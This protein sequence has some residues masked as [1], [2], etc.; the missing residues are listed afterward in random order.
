MHSVYIHIPFCENIC[1]YCAFTKFYYNEY[2]VTEYLDSLRYEIE[3]NYKGELI[4]TIYIGGG[5]PS[6]LSISELKILF[7]IINIFK[8]DKDVEF[9]I[10]VNPES[11]TKEKL[12][13]FKYNRVNRISMGVESTNNKSLKYLG[14]NYDFNTVR[15]KIKLIKSLGFNNINVDLMY[16]LPSET[17]EDLEMD[18]DNILDLDITHIS[19]YSLMIEE[20]TRLFINKEKNIDEEIDYEMYK[21]IC[22]KLKNKGFKHYEVSNFAKPNKESRHNLVYWE[23]T[24][25]YG[26]GL[27]ASGYILNDRYTNTTSMSKYLKHKYKE[28]V[29]HLSLQDIISYEL[30]LGFRKIDGINKNVFYNKYKVDIHDLYNINELLKK[31]DL[32]EN[33][34]NIYINYDKIYIENQILIN[35]VGENNGE[36]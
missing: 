21:L 34:S 24:H 13:L 28:D 22:N 2:R 9:T 17:L 27:G 5:T 33:T 15:D 11:I 23:N 25:Y 20:H 31:E 26:F 19:T 18:I 12:M 29:E 1:T 35:F 4:K 3:E 6:A 14:R 8:L 30:I 32:K 36:V 16:A 7:D 10:E